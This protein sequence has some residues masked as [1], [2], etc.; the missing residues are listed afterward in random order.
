M[1]KPTIEQ[2]DLEFSPKHSVISVGSTVY[3][4]N[5]DME[6]HNIYSKSLNNQF[7][8]G[9]MASGTGKAIHFTRAGPVVLRCNL[10]R[11][12]VG[13]IFVVPNGYFTQPDQAGNYEFKDVKSAGYILQ[14]WTPY[15]APHDVETNMKSADLNGDD[16]TFDFDIKTASLPGEIHDM[17]DPTDYGAIVDNIESE[18]MQAI[19]DWEAGKKYISRKRMLMAIT[20]H[21]DGGGL[22]G[23]LAKSFSEKRSQGLED[24]LDVIR[25]Q[26]SGIGP[27]AKTATGDSLRNK[28]RFAVTQLRTNVKE[29]EARLNP[30]PVELKKE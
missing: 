5:Q 7:N 24:K 12:M 23:A 30:D 2:R 4:F 22:K 29:L 13:T 25:K 18:M 15:L 21:Y 16:Q 28:A 3:F 9:A 26:I 17:V 10:H 14:A 1:T 27:D 11:D 8:L 20:K 19:K 6:V